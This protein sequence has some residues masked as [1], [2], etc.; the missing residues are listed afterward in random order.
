MYTHKIIDLLS[1]INL[2]ET[3]YKG[4]FNELDENEFKIL[5]DISFFTFQEVQIR[6]DQVVAISNALTTSLSHTDEG[7]YDPVKDG[8][9]I[10]NWLTDEAQTLQKLLSLHEESS[11]VIEAQERLC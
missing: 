9:H 3:L 5:K 7:I 4:R 11:G 8:L 1:K 6:L 10:A 2:E